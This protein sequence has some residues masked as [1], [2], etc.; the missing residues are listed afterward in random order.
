MKRINFFATKNDL[1]VVLRRLE[2]SRP[3]QYTRAGRLIG[4]VPEIWKSGED[5]PQLG[6]ATG[7]Q[8][9]ACDPFLVIEEAS[10]IQVETKRM[11]NGQERF[12]VYQYM[13][14]DSIELR[15]GGEW[16]DGAIIPGQ[17]TT[18]STAPVSQALMRSAHSAI[19][20]HFT[21][22]QAFW[23]GPE[24]LVALRSGK[25]LTQAVQSPPEFDLRE[26]AN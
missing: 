16:G 10:T 12:D 21:H 22:V 14:P 3:I 15:P 8:A 19:K 18:M 1:L 9:V 7:D 26:A 24:S 5:L 25:R 13:N 11:F 23:V 17:I 4:P 6:K 2:A 20:K